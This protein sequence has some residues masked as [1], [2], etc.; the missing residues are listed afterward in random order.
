MQRLDSSH[1]IDDQGSV[2]V[3]V[4]V[5]L[6]VLL[7]FVSFVADVGNWFQH[8]RHLQ[9]QADAAALAGAHDYVL[10]CNDTAILNKVHLYGGDQTY[11]QA[12]SL[13]DAFNQQTGSTPASNIGLVVNSRTFWQQPSGPVDNDIPDS[14]WLDHPCATQTIDVKMTE[15]NLPLFLLTAFNTFRKI[16]HINARARVQI[17]KE[18]SSKGSLPVAV[19]DPNPKAAAALVVDETNTSVTATPLEVQKL[20]GPTTATLNGKTLSQ[21]TNYQADGSQDLVV[22]VQSPRLGV[23]I[24]LSGTLNWT[25]NKTM[26]IQAICQQPLVECYS[27]GYAGPWQGID[28]IHGYPTTGTG[29]ITTGTPPILRDVRLFN[30]SCTDGSG[31][32]FILNGGCTVGVRAKIDIGANPPSSIQVAADGGAQSG[33]PNGNPKGCPLTYNALTQVWESTTSFLNVPATAGPEDITISWLNSGSNKGAFANAPHQRA[34]GANAASGPVQYMSVAENVSGVL[35]VQSNSLA[36]GV[37]HLVVTAGVLGSASVNAS[38]TADPVVSLRVVG[39]SQNQTLDCDPNSAI[40]PDDPGYSNLWQELA[41][42]CFPEYVQNQGTVCPNSPNTLWQP[43]PPGWPC[44]ALATGGQTNQVPKGMNVRILNDTNPTVCPPAGQRGH[45]NWS[46]FPNFPDGDPRIIQ[47]FI[48]PFGAFS[49]SGSGTVPVTGFAKFYIT[50]WKG[51][52]SGFNNPC[53]PPNG[54][55]TAPDGYIVGHF[56]Q[57][58]DK[59]G[60]GG[61]TDLCDLTGFGACV[62]VLNR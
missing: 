50:G 62:A 47:V 53:E 24:A 37:H 54:D 6:S 26:T 60:N 2:I 31:G 9:L 28:F 46:M 25:V 10:P 56:I 36:Y 59:L 12:N 51:Q 30:Q 34:Y 8:K 13:G 49:G 35:S 16:D 52:G 22:D 21:W 33:C 61:G 1:L 15:K 45:N 27:G 41:Y 44:V 23:V 43:Q 42:G 39:G 3:M 17:V 58:I 7:I 29:G 19:P 14:S 40:A 55:D 20:N 18:T 11:T 5:F 32:Y 4:A 57:Y 38:S 48:T